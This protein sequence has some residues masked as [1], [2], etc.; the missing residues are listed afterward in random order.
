VAK[1]IA[2]ELNSPLGEVVGYKVRF[3]DRLQ[4]GASVKL[5]TDG[6][7]LAETQT[8]PLLRAYDTLI[9]D[10]AHER[11]LNIDFLLGYLRQL[12]PRR[13]DLKVVVTSATIDAHRFAD[14]F[15]SPKGPAPVIQ[16]SGRLFPVEQ[17]FR[18]FEES[19]DYGMNEAIA[20]AWMSFGAA[21]RCR[22][23]FWFSCPA[24]ARS[25]R[26][27]TTCANTWPRPCC[28]MPRCCR[29]FRGLTKPSKTS[30]SSPTARRI[31]LATNVAETSLT[32]PGIRYVIDSGTAR[33]KRYSFSSKVEQL[34]GRA[35][36]AGRGQ[37]ARRSLR[38][39]GRWHLHTPV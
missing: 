21:A 5:M 9:I 37:P 32:V 4:P 28:A 2:E 39:G 23:T 6:I 19:R 36:L 10:E 26:P 11:S 8:D 30:V 18:P 20:D 25:A 15:A 34:L 38:P 16:V 13:P 22:V 33:V 17:R 35:H 24:S 12:L 7:L 14:Y 1:R 27:P 29:C 3:Q 31:V